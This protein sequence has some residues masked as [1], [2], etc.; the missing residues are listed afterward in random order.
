MSGTTAAGSIADETQQQ[1]E[2]ASDGVRIGLSGDPD[3]RQ[4]PTRGGLLDRLGRSSNAYRVED[5]FGSRKGDVPVDLSF[6]GG[7][8]SP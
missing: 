7:L 2:A 4:E 3:S 5:P 1:D 6:A 8:N